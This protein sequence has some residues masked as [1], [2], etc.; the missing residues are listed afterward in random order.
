MD[1]VRGHYFIDHMPAQ[2]MSDKRAK[3]MDPWMKMIKFI[4]T[5]DE[6]ENCRGV[7]GE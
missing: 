2:V 1:C 6:Y 3:L 7:P 4:A 5:F